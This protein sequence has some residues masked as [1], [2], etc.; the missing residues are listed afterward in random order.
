MIQA[1]LLDP[2]ARSAAGMSVQ[3]MV[4]SASRSSAWQICIAPLMRTLRA[5]TLSLTMSSIFGQQALFCAIRF[6]LLLAELRATGSDRAGGHL[7]AGISNH[8]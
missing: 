7:L 4:T 1:I 6:Q 2:E 3:L 5:A 8:N